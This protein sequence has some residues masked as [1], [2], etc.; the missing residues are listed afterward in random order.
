MWADLGGGGL[1]IGGAGA[2]VYAG[3]L[4]SC[5]LWWSVGMVKRGMLNHL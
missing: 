4:G 3:G 2:R 5:H 1:D